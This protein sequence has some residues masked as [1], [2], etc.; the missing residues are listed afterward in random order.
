MVVGGEAGS[1]RVRGSWDLGASLD[2][3]P[4]FLPAMRS[5]KP[6]LGFRAIASS[7]SELLSTSAIINWES[8]LLRICQAH[9]QNLRS[10]WDLLAPLLLP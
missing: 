2:D 10:Q 6:F 8:E 5:F 9:P 1:G 7:S 4:L 3:D